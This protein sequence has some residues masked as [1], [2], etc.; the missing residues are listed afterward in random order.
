MSKVNH[1]KHYGGG[2]W[3]YEAIKVIEA[4]CVGFHLGNALK[5]ISRADHKGNKLSDLKKALW[6][7][8][9][10]INNLEELNETT[11][12]ETRRE[13]SDTEANEH[14]SSRNGPSSDID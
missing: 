11:D 8:Q 10:E 5:Y 6:Y 12:Q 14:W 4:W 2:D 13:S 7:I 1:P 3:T 9:R